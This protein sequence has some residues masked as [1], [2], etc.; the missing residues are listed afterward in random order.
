MTSVVELAPRRAPAPAAYTPQPSDEVLLAGFARSDPKMSSAFIERF[1]AA[2]SHFMALGYS[3]VKAQA[4]AY[5]AID[6][7]L[8]GQALMLSYNDSWML[9]LKSFIVT[10]P[11]IL[12]I[13]KPRGRAAAGEMH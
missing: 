12:V 11:A 4:A 1:Q 9:I 7:A 13:R 3:Y 6:Q 10:A 5:A 8:T 2:L